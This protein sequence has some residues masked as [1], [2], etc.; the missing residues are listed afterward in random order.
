[1]SD[2]E[3]QLII[4][5]QPPSEAQEQRCKNAEKMIR[6]AIQASDSLKRRNISIFTQGSYANNTNTARTSDVDVGVVCHDVNFAQYPDGMSRE[7]FGLVAADYNFATFKDEVGAAL[8]TYFKNGT[9]TRG[10]KA[11]DIKAT[12]HH[13]EADVAPFFDHR[14]YASSGSYNEGVELRSDDGGKRVI[15]WP[16]QHMKNG[17]SKNNDTGRRYKRMVRVIKSINDQTAKPVPGFLLECL[18]WNVPNSQLG[19]ATY[20]QTLRSCLSHLH[21]NLQTTI[22]DEWGEVSELKYLFRGNPWTKSEAIA[23]ILSIWNQV[24]L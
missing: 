13:V 1:M 5:A 11:F 14:R 19:H 2:L 9:V 8:T 6:N 20:E 16:D 23:A 7:D 4:W 15:N 24:E 12:S 21:A 17:I 18:M 10:N 3:T 22:S